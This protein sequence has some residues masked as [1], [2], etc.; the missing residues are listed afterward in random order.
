MLGLLQELGT[1]ECQLDRPGIIK[2]AYQGSGWGGGF[3][4]FPGMSLN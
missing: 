2:P 1:V 3:S 4:M